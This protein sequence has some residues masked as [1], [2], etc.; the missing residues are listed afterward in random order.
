MTARFGWKSQ[1]SSPADLGDVLASSLRLGLDPVGGA[2]PECT[3]Q[4]GNCSL[5]AAP[6]T[7]EHKY[8]ELGRPRNG[9]SLSLSL[10]PAFHTYDVPAASLTL[11]GSGVSRGQGQG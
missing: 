8:G 1:Q 3:W 4:N 11:V 7:R 10:C 2:S 6:S 5:P 9:L